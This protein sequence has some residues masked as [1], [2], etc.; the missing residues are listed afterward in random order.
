MKK[1]TIAIAMILVLFSLSFSQGIHIYIGQSRAEVLRLMSREPNYVDEYVTTEG[2]FERCQWG[3]DRAGYKVV[4]LF[5]DG[6]VHAI[7]GPRR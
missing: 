6:K 1:I 3:S 5:R 2:R 4:I 7:Q